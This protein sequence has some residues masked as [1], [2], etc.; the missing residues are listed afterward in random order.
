MTALEYLKSLPFSPVSTEGNRCGP[1]SNSELRRW[2]IK[3]SVVINGVR[4]LP[5]DKIC[6]PIA[7]LVFFP[8][9]K[10]KCTMV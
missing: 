2:L 7:S 3:R 9:G 8:K 5:H 1:A 10:R 4:P 6:F